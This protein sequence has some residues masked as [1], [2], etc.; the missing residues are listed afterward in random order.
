[1]RLPDLV[2][3]GIEVDHLGRSGKAYYQEGANERS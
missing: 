2:S 3:L 1:M